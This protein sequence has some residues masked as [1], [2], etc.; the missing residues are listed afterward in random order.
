MGTTSFETNDA[1]PPLYVTLV[2]H[3]EVT[4]TLIG[5]KGSLISGEIDT[6]DSTGINSYKP[7]DVTYDTGLSVSAAD[8]VGNHYF[9]IPFTTKEINCCN[10]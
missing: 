9:R 4:A 6:G 7:F 2:S 3:D 1:D 10:K 8:F 5:I